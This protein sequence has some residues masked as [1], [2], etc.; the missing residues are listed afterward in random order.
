MTNAVFSRSV[1]IAALVLGLSLAARSAYAAPNFAAAREHYQKG[2]K[3]FEL[4]IYQEAI[5]EYVAAYKIIDDPAILYNLA[6]SHRLAGHIPEALRFYRQY[7]VKNPRAENRTECE[8]RI[9]ELGKTIEQQ[10]KAQEQ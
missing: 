1:S 3:A 8:S 4:G 5:D 9:A 10:K 2:T 6:Q 7:L